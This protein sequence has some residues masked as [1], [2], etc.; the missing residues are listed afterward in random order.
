MTAILAVDQSTSGTKALLFDEEGALLAKTALPHQQYYPQAGWVEHDAKEIYRNTVQVI[1]TVLERN[2]SYRDNIACLSITNQRETFVVFDR[3]TGQPLHHAIVWQCRRGTPLCTELIAAGHEKRVHEV[4]GLKLD[5]YFP[6][7]K[8][9]WLLD[10]HPAIKQQV[11]AGNALIGTI[12]TYLLYRLTQGSI[13]ATDHTNASR[14]LL[15][16]IHTLAWSEELCEL[17]DVPITALPDIQDSSANFGHTTCDGVLQ[18][19]VPISGIMGDSQAALFAQ[20]CFVAG[21]AKVTF[22]TGSSVLLNIGDEARL[23]DSG[24]VTTIAWVHAGKPVYSLEGIINFT[25][26]TI[27]WLRNQMQLINDASETEALAQEVED[28]GGVYL[29]PAFVGLSAPYWQPDARAALIG[30]TPG[31]HRAHIVRAALEAIAY[32]IRDVL[33]MMKADSGI[34][35]ER[36]HGDGGMVNNQFL[37][38]FVADMTRVPLRASQLAELS[39]QGAVMMGMLGTG[40]V[41]NLDA[42]SSLPH[43]SL[44]Y[45]P[46]MSLTKADE[47]YAGWQVAIGQLLNT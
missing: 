12:D 29:I 8:I 38:Q 32:R 28:T 20:R 21:S 24:I 16:D 39:A 15:Y 7:S 25:G 37:M 4:S 43:H 6:A 18:T 14:T 22:G 23:S 46:Q 26:A 30:L 36:L 5:T 31:S 27:E 2:P 10:N 17:F 34:P 19:P 11:T 41:N 33:E 13:F 45:S 1:R 3:A 40:Q 42:L 35:L 47:F 44:D 9:K